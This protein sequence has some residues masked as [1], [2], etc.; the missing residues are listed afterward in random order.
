MK[1]VS[2]SRISSISFPPKLY[3]EFLRMAKDRGM[4]QSELV[5]DALRRYQKQE[6]EW[7]ELLS[8]GRKRAHAA[9][10]RTEQDVERLIDESRK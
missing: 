4:T 10:I 9:G 6:E 3:K 2:V 8:Y 1:T 5:R 7:Q